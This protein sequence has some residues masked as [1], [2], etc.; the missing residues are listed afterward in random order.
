MIIVVVSRNAVGRV[1]TTLTVVRCTRVM[2]PGTVFEGCGGMTG[3]AIQ[4]GRKVGGVGLGIHT[5]R[6][7]TIMTGHT[8]V[9]DAGMIEHRASEGK[10][11]ASRMTDATI[12][13][14]LYVG[15]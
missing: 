9:H 13:V 2:N 3:A 5:N 15:V 4:I 14:C 11:E 1:V 12:L 7:I 6:R 8:I 10:R